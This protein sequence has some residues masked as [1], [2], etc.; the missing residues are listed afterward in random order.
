MDTNTRLQRNT[1]TPLLGDT[2][3]LL[4]LMAY[5]KY[6]GFIMPE[7]MSLYDAMDLTANFYRGNKWKEIFATEIASES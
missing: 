2:E 7:G 4:G 5:E 3:M 6:Y 1:D